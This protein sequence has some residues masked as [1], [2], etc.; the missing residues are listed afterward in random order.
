MF[1]KV[2]SLCLAV[3]MVAAISVSMVSCDNSNADF[4]LGVIL[5]HDEASTYDLN[6]IEAVN[7]AAEELG[8]SEDQIGRASCR[9]RV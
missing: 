9:E 3:L 1:K 7:R 5:L 2:L 4:K 8:L 6:F